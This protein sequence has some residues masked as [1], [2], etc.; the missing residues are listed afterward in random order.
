MGYRWNDFVLNQQLLY[1]IESRLITS[2]VCQRQLQLYGHVARY[3]E[4]GPASWVIS[5]R[6]NPELRRPRGCSQSSWLRQVNA[7]C[8]KLIGMACMG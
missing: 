3:P 2:L 5:E 4:A 6:D 8:W 7:S 1:D